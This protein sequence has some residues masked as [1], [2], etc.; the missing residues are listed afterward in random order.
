MIDFLGGVA[1]GK[2]KALRRRQAIVAFASMVGGLTL[3][4]MTS[5]GELCR[6]IL[7]D[8]AHSVPGSVRATV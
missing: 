6:E 5:D 4:R 7:K 1:P 8:V 3:A 2:T